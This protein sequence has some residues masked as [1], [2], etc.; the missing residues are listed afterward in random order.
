[1]NNKI[2]IEV[3]KSVCPVCL[4]SRVRKRYIDLENFKKVLTFFCPDCNRWNIDSD[5][6]TDQMNEE[7]INYKIQLEIEK[8]RIFTDK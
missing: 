4:G 1:M 6:L 8:L 7:F 2:E 5:L 3:V